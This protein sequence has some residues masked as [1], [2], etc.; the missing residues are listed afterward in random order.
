MGSLL[1]RSFLLH[2]RLEQERGLCVS[3]RTVIRPQREFVVRTVLRHVRTVLWREL[4]DR[5]I[6][7][8]DAKGLCDILVL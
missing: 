6:Q 3:K 1:G 5:R 2:E 7:L 4:V 8:G